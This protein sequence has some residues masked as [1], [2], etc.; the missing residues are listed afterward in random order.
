MKPFLNDEVEDDD[1]GNDDSLS[2]HQKRE[3]FDGLE[4]KSFWSF[5][6]PVEPFSAA[7]TRKH[8]NISETKN[9]WKCFQ[10]TR[11]SHKNIVMVFFF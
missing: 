8:G 5:C 4:G 2:R 3:T 11:K 7:A 6:S 9:N 10:L 1:G